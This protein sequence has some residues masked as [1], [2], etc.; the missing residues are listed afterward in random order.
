MAAD[1]TVKVKKKKSLF[2][3]ISM[4][5]IALMIVGYY[6]YLT[7]RG[8]SRTE[9]DTSNEEILTATQKVLLRD[10]STNYPPTPREV[11]KY[12]S[13]IT[14]CFYN[15]DNTEE[16]IE[17]IKA[18]EGV[19]DA[20]GVY[21][22]SAK[23]FDPEGNENA[24]VDVISMTE[25]ISLPEMTEGRLP[26]SFF[27]CAVE[28]E[29]ADKLG[30][31]T[32]DTI[33][34]RGHDG[35]SA[36]YLRHRAFRITGIFVHADHYAKETYSAGN[37]YVLVT[38]NSFDTDALENCYMRAVAKLDRPEG[39]KLIGKPYD[40]FSSDG[41][42]RIKA[43]A[44]E[45]APMREEAVKDRY[46]EKIDEGQKK[47]DD[48]DAQ[49]KSSRETLDEYA[50]KIAD[51]EREL[52]ENRKKLDDAGKELAAA[53]K[54]LDAGK[55]ELD[56]NKSRLD[57]AQ[58]QLDEGAARLAD[59]W[60]QIEDKKTE[61]RGKISSAVEAK[62]AEYAPG[63]A[64]TISW[65]GRTPADMNDPSLNA[66]VFRITSDISVNVTE[67]TDKMYSVVNS[68]VHRALDGRIKPGTDPAR[69]F[70]DEEIQ[71]C[72]DQIN[73]AL[74]GTAIGETSADLSRWNN[75]HDKY[76]SARND[77][78]SAKE[79][80]DEGAAA[81]E[82]G[83][84]EYQ[85]GLKKY[86]SGMN[87]YDQAV[88]E[89]ED[90]KKQLAEGEKKYAEGLKEYEA[91]LEELQKAKDVVAGLD[92]CRWVVLGAS[93]NSAYVH[94]R[95]SAENIR[96]LA[97]TFAMLFVLIGAL[98]IYAT[99]A[100]I[101]D[102][103]R[104]QLGTV[105][106]LGLYNGE[107][108]AKYL[109]FGISAVLLGV[110]LGTALGYFGIQWVALMAH[111]T[112]YV[113]D[114][115]PK[116]FNAALTGI[117]AAAAVLIAVISVWSACSE[118]V[119]QPA[120]EL[121][122][123][124]MP[125]YK[126]KASPSK[127]KGSSLYSKL[128]MRNMRNDARRIFVTIISVAGCCILL[129]IGFTMKSGIMDAL[130]IQYNKLLKYDQIV[131]FSEESETAER[132]IQDALQKDNVKYTKAYYR[133][134]AFSTGR[135]LMSGSV[136]CAD[137]NELDELFALTDLNTGKPLA[138]ADDGLYI[139]R[140]ISKHYHIAPGDT[141][142]VYDSG[143]NPY[144]IKV[145]GVYE[146]Y[147]G[148][149]IIMSKAAYKEAFGEDAPANSFFLRDSSDNSGLSG[150]LMRIEGC[151]DIV[152]NRELYNNSSKAVAA[153]NIIILVM[154]LAAGVFAY[155]ILLN[156]ANMY[157]NQKK[158]ELT[159]MRVNGFTTGEAVSYVAR[160]AVVTTLLGIILG[161]ALGSVF[162]WAILSFIEQRQ[163]GF[164]LTPNIAA[165]ILSAWITAVYSF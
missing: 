104:K 81:Y 93:G 77:F 58:A 76:I 24:S 112:F 95:S 71:S 108:A 43:L 74:Q 121:M 8:A 132:E 3:I 67:L 61:V 70:T 59:A 16:D 75:E 38:D 56:A 143:M 31:E 144:E 22:T 33:T 64:G 83:L 130:E 123:E 4:I 97:M 126:V 128:I 11:V 150:E 45:R 103:Q 110:V 154:I 113:T 49:L 25:R 62:L 148:L 105:K 96:K 40:S 88:K 133:Q 100:R 106:A 69:P 90:A 10:L 78:L 53:K 66:S 101:I 28:K 5:V 99:V 89:M 94:A 29:T 149:N 60:N 65:A 107:A 87:K 42:D 114:G 7:N 120:V 17:A 72:I 6:Y 84:K 36:P 163:A 35:G 46:R 19:S 109:I 68:V 57:G 131:V 13:E 41:A 55:A 134:T 159:I 48:A 118:L 73:S 153:L 162:G 1:K 129:V 30:L 51:G 125:S 119:R 146:Y 124:K 102:E 145:A 158:R 27:E 156:L 79:K 86:D 82:A 142:T 98:V 32:G 141:I 9:E 157:I 91:G 26:E 63:Y 139:T 14:Q 122:K 135:E 80:Y 44:D 92:P 140:R 34:V 127:H 117:A 152:S 136:I 18:V 20:E 111:E 23:L 12:F 147:F 151:E 15:E 138:V 115:I 2:T 85:D 160:E 155:F 37:R 39:M 116:S 47:L 165:W 161:I 164:V 50:E 52:D 54:K 137:R 21:Q